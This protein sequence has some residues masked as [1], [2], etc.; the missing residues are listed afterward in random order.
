MDGGY[1]ALE[2]SWLAGFKTTVMLNYLERSGIF[3]PEID[4]DPHHGKKRT[5]SFRDLIVLRS[6]KRLLDMGLRPKRIEKAIKTFHRIENLPE[7][8]DALLAFSRKAGMFVVNGS[9]VLYC[10]SPETIVDL[11]KDGQLEMA[12]V[13]DIPGTLG[14]VA[15]AAQEYRRCRDANPAAQKA[16]VLQTVTKKHGL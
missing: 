13:L 3:E 14:G 7:D 15:L 9:D 5:Y 2:L 4:R 12:F 6:I 10:E 11:T 8:F 16:A 1:S